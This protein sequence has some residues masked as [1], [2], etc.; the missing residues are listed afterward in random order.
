MK[1]EAGY[2]KFFNYSILLIVCLLTTINFSKGANTIG[3]AKVID[4]WHYSETFGEIRNFRV[5]LPPAY[6]ESDTKRFPVIYYYHGW[7]QRYFGSTRR[8]EYPDEDSLNISN[9]ISF[10]ENHDVIVIRPDGYDRSTNQVYELR[11]YNIGSS[12]TTHRQFPVYFPE[13]VEHIDKNFR[14]IPDREHRAI[15]GLSMGGFMTWWISGKYPDM[16]CAAGNFCGSPEFVNGPVDFPVEYRHIDM[17][18]NYA[19]VNLRLHY[20][21]QDFIRYYHQDVN[22]VWVNGMDNYE[23]KIYQ[24]VHL[25]L[26]LH[27]MFDFIMNTFESPLDKPAIWNHIDVYPNFNIWG[28]EVISDRITEGFTVLEHVSIGGFKCSIREFLPDGSLM[29]YVKVTVLTPPIYEKNQSYLITDFELS[30]QSMNH[31]TL[32]SD[33]D[34]RLKIEIDGGLHEI[35]INSPKEKHP[36]MRVASFEIESNGKASSGQKTRLS[37]SLLNKGLATATGIKAYI[38][39]SKSDVVQM[40]DQ[41]VQFGDIEENQI[42]DGLSKFSFMIIPDSIELVK[43]SLVISDS[44]SNTWFESILVPVTNNS[45]LNNDFVVADGKEVLIFEHADDT[46]TVFVGRG[47]GDGV[48]NPG[49]HIVVLFK[50]G[51]AFRRAELST[52]DKFVNPFGINIRKSDNWGS[53]DHVGASAKYSIPVISS[54]TPENHEIEFHYK[55]QLPKERPEHYFNYGKLKVIVKGKDN[56]PPQMSWF[57][58]SGDNTVHSRL[59]DGSE[60]TKVIARFTSVRYPGNDFEILLTDDGKNGDRVDNDLVFSK[61]VDTGKFNLYSVEIEAVD[62]YGN[63][64]IQACEGVFQLH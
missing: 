64:Q 23:Y 28:Y 50:D 42:S 25:S 61:K 11:P 18:G 15:S 22:R 39:N 26:G 6:S 21:D 1:A 10:V 52:I 40:F 51:R 7:S 5:I 31:K 29:P 36:N 47:N 33:Q 38:K 54:N 13:L 14:T 3:K 57:K 24:G 27:D 63:K 58:I 53:F 45:S 19:G 32:R 35:G 8:S 48:V 16:V 56:T 20:G 37:V 30:G 62:I 41:E 44:K 4:C 49:E 2:L 34:G 9:I 55:L 60:I 59:L 46:T 12:N 43:L 17:F